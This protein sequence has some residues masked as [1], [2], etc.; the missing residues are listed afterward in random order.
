MAYDPTTGLETDPRVIAARAYEQQQAA[1]LEAQLRSFR[2]QAIIQF[3]D[4]GLAGLGGFQLDPSVAALVAQAN[5]SGTSMTS[6]LRHDSD[7]RRRSIINQ[8]A[9]S[10][11][12][13]SGDTG[14]YATEE[15]KRAGT[16]LFDAR[17]AVLAALRGEQANFLTARQGLRMGT[18]DAYNQAY[19]N[20]LDHP[21][22]YYGTV[23]PP[24]NPETRLKIPPWPQ[25]DPP[26]IVKPPP[27]PLA[28][29]PMRPRREPRPYQF[30][31]SGRG[32]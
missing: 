21:E 24:P 19:Q 18:V 10:G 6:R 4:A 16:E 3:G 17:Q 20:R 26:P 1:Y 15:D 12:I 30:R 13:N 2:E 8:L 27:R 14:Y 31:Y 9:G 7:L 11:M 5:T 28:A 22:V 29:A 32:F 23:T 25:E